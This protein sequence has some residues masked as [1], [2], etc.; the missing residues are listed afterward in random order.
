M[1]ELTQ[2][3]LREA[4]DYDPL[5][6]VFTWKIATGCV[7]VGDIADCRH[8]NGYIKVSIDDKRYLAHRL[9]FLYMTGSMPKDTVDHINMD[10]SD[11]RWDNLREAT[12][13][14]NGCNRKVKK[15]SGTGFKGVYKYRHYD[16]YSARITY[17]GVRYNLG[18]YATPEEAHK[19]YCAKAEELHREFH[20]A[21]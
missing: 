20:K 1:T 18:Y 7:T 17:Q 4:L 12:Y 3:R 6:G 9:V 16:R 2:D 21:A 8:R 13:S 5:T 10:K 11:N 15:N 14:Q 19:A